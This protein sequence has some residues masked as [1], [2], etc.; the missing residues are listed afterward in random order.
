M[1]DISRR[2]FL[3]LA[4][5]S[6]GVFA[7]G[8]MAVFGPQRTAGTIYVNRLRKSI[9]EFGFDFD[10]GIS[11]L[12]HLEGE[13][14]EVL[15]PA[16]PRTLY[17]ATWWNAPLPAD[18]K[19]HAERAFRRAELDR[20]MKLGPMR[21]DFEE[22]RRMMANRGPLVAEGEIATVFAADVIEE[23]GVSDGQIELPAPISHVSVGIP[24]KATGA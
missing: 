15:A 24:F 7:V 16:E 14:V 11:G 20:N 10:D 6:V 23:A 2:K 9:Q 22:E 17:V 13:T 12:D 4:P 19:A 3:A 1:T 8:G 21:R 5:A 18:F